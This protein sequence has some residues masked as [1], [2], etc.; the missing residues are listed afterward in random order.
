MKKYLSYLVLTALATTLFTSS[1]ALYAQDAGTDALEPSDVDNVRLIEGDGQIRVM[2]DAAQDNVGV[3]AY[4]IYRGTQ[5]VQNPEDIY[6]LPVITTS[7]VTEYVVDNLTN[8]TTYYFAVT[9][10]DAAGNESLNYSLEAEGTPQI[11]GQRDASIEDNGRAPE[12]KNVRAEDGLTVLIEFSEP[13]WLPQENPESAF[14]IRNSADDSQLAVERAEIYAD[15]ETGATVMLMTS[16][17]QE[18]A[19]YELTVGIE[20]QDYYDNPLISGTADTGVFTGAAVPEPDT[21]PPPSN[22]GNNADTDGPRITSAVADFN[23]RITVYFDEPVVIPPNATEEVFIFPRD[24]GDQELMVKNV[25]ASVDGKIV[26]VTTEAQRAVDYD[27]RLE[28]F[29]DIAGNLIDV[30]AN[31][32]TVAGNA[33]TTLQDLIPPEDVTNLVAKLKEAEENV[34]ELSW[35][36]S[37]NSAGDLADYLLYQGEGED[38]RVFGPSVSVGSASDK[39]EVRDLEPGNWYSF[40]LSATDLTG[41]ESDGAFA[42]FYLPETGPGMAAAGLTA[43][44]MG[45]ARRRKKRQQ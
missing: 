43:L 36:H 27:I 9:A 3:T 5:S 16:P 4:K 30:N 8:G 1:T 15:D 38:A 6:N 24:R 26:F 32:W 41:N 12:V 2:W 34:V 10:V 35:D 20:I 22:S 39:V 33:P 40:R 44:M 18:G 31:A 28:N 19:E 14:Q 21:A 23:D 37:V 11:N 7:N 25:S 13:V 42:N 29:K 17:Q 45:W